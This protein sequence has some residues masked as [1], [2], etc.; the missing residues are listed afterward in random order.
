MLC[1]HVGVSQKVGADQASTV[2][3][4]DEQNMV[5]TQSGILFSLKK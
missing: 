2:R 4:K 3:G 5:C 1:V